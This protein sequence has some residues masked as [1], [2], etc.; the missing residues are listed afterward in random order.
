MPAKFLAAWLPWKGQAISLFE[1]Q[2]DRLDSDPE[3]ILHLRQHLEETKNQ[4]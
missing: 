2:I 4:A 3:A 1:T